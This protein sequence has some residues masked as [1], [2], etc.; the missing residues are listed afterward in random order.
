M[1]GCTLLSLTYPKALAEGRYRWRHDKVLEELANLSMR[2]KWILSAVVVAIALVAVVVTLVLTLRTPPIP[3]K[4][5]PPV[6]L[7]SPETASLTH[8]PSILGNYRFAAVAPD[9]MKHCSTI[10]V[11]IMA[12]KGG[13]AVDAAIATLL[14][15]GVVNAHSM[16]VGGGHFF[17]IY[18]KKTDT[19]KTI[20]SREMAP[21]AAHENMFVDD[22]LA[23]KWGPL[24]IGVPGEIKGYWEAYSNFGSGSVPW[25]ELFEPTIKMCKEGFPVGKSLASA[26]RQYRNRLPN[27]PSIMEIIWNKEENRFLEAGDIMKREKFAE[28]LEVISEDPHSFYNGTLATKIAEELKD[29]G[30]IITE[31]DLKNY[32]SEIKD[33]LAIHLS[34]G[35]MTVYGVR[36]PSS[37]VVLQYIMGILDGYNFSSESL[38]DDE[39]STTTYHRIIEAFKFAY[40][41]RT[42]LG[43]ENFLQPGIEDLIKNLTS[44]DYATA[45]RHK[46]WDNQTHDLLY[47]GPT[48]YDRETKGTAHL[49][50]LGPDGSAV[51]CTS[52]INFYFGSIMRGNKTGILYNNEMYDFATPNTTNAFGM[53]AS[54]ANFIKPGKRP[55]SSM[56]P[57]IVLDADR[58]VRLI[59]GGAGG[60]RITTVTSYKDRDGEG[61]DYHDAQSKPSETFLRDTSACEHH[62]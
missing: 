55:L 46:I 16:G 50:V 21:V 9:V 38:K 58:N 15:Q 25:K 22:K 27:Y 24:A 11:N 8:S 45:T 13:N 39:T 37:G 4:V 54:P 62:Q 61:M 28:T 7:A 19:V 3:D 30:A 6:S 53:P 2:A 51:A 5:G 17:T 43:D 48:F 10:G 14:C 33:P 59:T 23:A 42:E 41:K 29:M 36:P 47:Y 31:E 44:K 32:T 49:S 1:P 34:N 57:T 12:V 18:D 52:T 40:A 26:I 20:D 56:A 60:T 35:N